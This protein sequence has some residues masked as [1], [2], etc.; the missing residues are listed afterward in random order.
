MLWV[1]SD[2][3]KGSVDPCC[4]LLTFSHLELFHWFSNRLLTVSCVYVTTFGLWFVV[5]IIE[6]VYCGNLEQQVY[7]HNNC[8]DI[9]C[10]FCFKSSF[11]NLALYCD[12]E[13]LKLETFTII[14]IAL[15]PSCL[16]FRRELVPQLQI[17][18]IDVGK[19][20]ARPC[21][22]CN[23]CCRIAPDINHTCLL[24]Y[25]I[26]LPLLLGHWNSKNLY[27]YFSY[28]LSFNQLNLCHLCA[29]SNVEVFLYFCEMLTKLTF[30]LQ[31]NRTDMPLDIC[32][33]FIPEPCEGSATKTFS[34]SAVNVM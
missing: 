11:G 31:I 27:S 20:L 28:L 1:N 5:E 8:C 19:L 4:A 6:S 12:F 9:N 24:I 17:T 29:T 18:W 26:M 2:D 3:Y 7:Y 15:D 14:D 16:H 34:A 21:S 32:S 25:F 13:E 33:E 22:F 30:G 23:S 10:S